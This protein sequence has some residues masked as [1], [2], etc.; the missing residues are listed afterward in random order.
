MGMGKADTATKAYTRQNEVFADAFNFYLY[1]GK[2][3]IS[4]ERLHELDTA[5]LSFPHGTDR[6]GKPVQKYR[7]VFKGLAAMEDG[8][9][10]YL[11]LGIE[12]QSAVHYAAPVKNLLYDVLQ[13]VN[14]VERAAKK[15]RKEKDYKGRR[16]GEF[17]SGFYREDKLLP[18]IT[19]MILFSPDEWDAPLSLHEMMDVDD[20][21]ILAMIP[22]YRVHLVAPADI[23]EQDF[24]KFHTSLGNVLTFIKYSRDK[25]RMERWLNGDG[26]DVVLGREEVE[27]LNTCV[28]AKLTIKSDEEAINV[29]EAIRKMNEEAVEKATKKVREETTENAQLEGIKNL[30]KNLNLTAE[31]AMAALGIPEHDRARIAGRLR[32]GK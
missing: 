31:Q 16:E 28:N 1:G 8:R 13:Y 27:V 7:D 29:C 11:L 4:A 3:V 21:A 23:P 15:H 30:I 19:L 18:V 20:P 5:E 6:T 32:D 26:A 24:G 2:Q 10:A 25:E 14:Q 22:D 12:N 17:L 9:A